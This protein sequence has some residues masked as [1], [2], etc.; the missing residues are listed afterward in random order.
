[1]EHIG[2]LTQADLVILI[3]PAGVEGMHTEVIIREI[4]KA[5]AKLCVITDSKRIARNS[6][7]EISFPLPGV[8][9]AVDMFIMQLF[10]CVVEMEYRKQY[11]EE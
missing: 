5:G 1:M 11:L 4:R 3:A 6:G 9:Q 7:A 10:L 2:V 8:K